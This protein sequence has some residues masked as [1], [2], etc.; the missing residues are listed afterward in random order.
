M[1]DPEELMRD[2]LRHRADLTP[3][4]ATPVREVEAAALRLRG[5]RR[6]LVTAGAAA[7]VAVLAVPLAV[8]TADEPDAPP[9]PP[10]T[11]TVSPGPPSSDP[12]STTDA[13]PD[14]PRVAYA[15][16]RRIHEPDGDVFLLARGRGVSG[17]VPYLGGYLVADDRYFEGTVGLVRYDADG[18]EVAAWATAG[19]PVSSGDGALVAW[20]SFV[21]P[22]TG[23]T[24]P[25]LVHRASTSADRRELTQELDLDQPSVVGLV[26]DLVVLQ[27]GFGTG[28]AWVTDLASPPRRL[29]ALDRATDA[30]SAQGLV[31]G[32]VEGGALGRVVDVA[33]GEVL[34]ERRGVSV[35]AFSPDGRLAVTTRS[36]DGVR[37][38]VDAR[39]GAEVAEIDSADVEDPPTVGELTWEDEDHLLG[40]LELECCAQLV[41]VGL[42]G[43]VTPA[44]PR[45]ANGGTGYAFELSS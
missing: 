45:E 1:S 42:D 6:A 30:S 40:A 5:R 4:A 37:A 29:D 17:F 34:W 2:A 32:E 9:G 8:V 7:A 11:T 13:A 21:V 20:T 28:G 3:Y 27:G 41:R 15:E 26:G 31:A 36:D 19:R 25:T 43:S 39:T 38:I 35:G 16:G 33:T 10:A 18:T 12:T 22:E 44:G 23:E 14:A 24:G